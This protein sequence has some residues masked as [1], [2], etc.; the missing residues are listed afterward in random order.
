MC[1]V[2]R[3]KFKMTPIYVKRWAI[4]SQE[5]DLSGLK[6]VDAVLDT[7]LG[8]DDVLVEMQ[9]GSINYRDL[10][11]GKVFPT[12]KSITRDERVFHTVTDI[13]NRGNYPWSLSQG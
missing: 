12:P 7:N 2:A 13:Y 6:Y 5:E 1:F 9:A 4:D 3:S 8:P 11:I 10:V